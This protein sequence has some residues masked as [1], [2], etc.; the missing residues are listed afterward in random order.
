MFVNGKDILKCLLVV[1][2]VYFLIV[3]E[4]LG[5]IEKHTSLLFQ[6][7]NSFIVTDK[8]YETRLGASVIKLFLPIIYE[9]LY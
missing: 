8:D 2:L 6:S 7:V 4:I 9:L 5:L 3:L 1:K